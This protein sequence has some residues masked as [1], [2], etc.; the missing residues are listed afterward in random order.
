MKSFNKWT[1]HGRVLSQLAYLIATVWVMHRMLTGVRGATIEKYCP[2]GGFE[3]LIPWLRNTGSLCSLSTINISIMIAVIIMT[4][5]FKRVFCS[6]IC[7]LGAVFEWTGMLSRKMGWKW[8][9]P[10]RADIYMKSLKYIVVIAVLAVTY[11]YAELYFRD[12]DPYYVIFTAG[13]GHGIERFGIP[14]TVIILL[15][16][17]FIPLFFC[18]YLCPLAASLAPFG[19]FGLVSV[20]RNTQTCTNC[21]LCDKACEWGITVSERTTVHSPECSNCQDC[22]RECPVPDALTLRIGGGK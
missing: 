1:K 3:T 13:T 5:L 7:P 9:M 14:F 17:L 6:H 4:I 8:R 12:F 20:T 16:S 22:I 2:F 15:V 10:R 21:K 19:K 18:R 11:K